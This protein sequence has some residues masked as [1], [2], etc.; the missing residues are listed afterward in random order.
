MKVK[1]FPFNREASY[2]GNGRCFR[3]ASSPG[4]ISLL[5][6]LGDLQAESAK[7]IIQVS[8]LPPPERRQSFKRPSEPWIHECQRRLSS[9]L[10]RLRRFMTLPWSLCTTPW[11][12]SRRISCESWESPCLP[13]TIDPY[14]RNNP[15]FM[16]ANKRELV[17]LS[18]PSKYHLELSS[19]SVLMVLCEH[20]QVSGL[21]KYFFV[22]KKTFLCNLKSF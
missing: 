1:R 22:M 14:F 5:L 10:S 13:S 16:S 17:V 21:G 7:D 11:S 6:G 2:Q 8:A 15:W 19:C 20:L 12:W 4:S 9:Q 18:P 3:A